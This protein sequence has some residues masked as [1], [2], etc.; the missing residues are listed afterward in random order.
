MKLSRLSAIDVLPFPSPRLRG[1]GKGEGR[2]L[3]TNRVDC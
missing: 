3:G 1:E 2:F